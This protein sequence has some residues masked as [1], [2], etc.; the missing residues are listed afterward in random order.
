MKGDGGKRA[1]DV[2][3]QHVLLDET[4]LKDLKDESG[5]ADFQNNRNI[6]GDRCA[7]WIDGSFLQG[8]FTGTRIGN[9]AKPDVS[10]A[11]RGGL[12]A[13]RREASSLLVGFADGSVRPISPQVPQGTWTGLAGRNDGIVLRID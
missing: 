9:D 6:A 10:C 13:L 11:G 7:R 2:R 4:A 8:T 1:V 5:V 12:S 3:R